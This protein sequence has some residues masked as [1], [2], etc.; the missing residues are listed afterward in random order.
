MDFETAMNKVKAV[1]QSTEHEFKA[2][3]NE[4]KLLGR[5][6]SF[7]A[8]EAA[9]AMSFLGGWLEHWPDH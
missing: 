9:E 4:A 2:L 3:E 7:S 1:T 6:T 5:T 8:S